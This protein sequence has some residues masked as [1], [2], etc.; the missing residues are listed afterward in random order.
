MND[1]TSH[2]VQDTV[3]SFVMDTFF[4]DG[5]D[6]DASFL[7]EGIIDSTGMLELVAF[8]ETSFAITIADEE[9]VPDNLDSLRKVAA[10]V[11]RKRGG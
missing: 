9:L 1:T 5:F 8:V 7:G 2:G 3:R 4:V 11:S 10:F 6:D